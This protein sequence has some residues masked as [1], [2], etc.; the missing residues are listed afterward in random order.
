[1]KGVTF[2]R[3]LIIS[4]LLL[5]SVSGSG[6]METVREGLEESPPHGGRGI[7]SSSMNSVSEAVFIMP[8]VADAS[9]LTRGL[10]PGTHLHLLRPGE[11]LA[12][13][14]ELLA[15]Y[16][17]LATV[18][19]ISHGSPGTLSLGSTTLTSRNIAAY[20]AELTAMGRAIR[21]DGDILL[22]G[23]NVAEG[24][25]GQ[26]LVAG[27]A[28]WTA[29]DIAASTTLSGAA[30]R[31]GDWILES[32]SG[33]VTAGSLL[34]DETGY[35]GIL[36]T[37][38]V[39]NP[40][41]PI[42]VRP[43]GT[44]YTWTYGTGWLPPNPGDTAPVTQISYHEV[45]WN[46]AGA[47]PGPEDSVLTLGKF[48]YSTDGGGTWTDYAEGAFVPNVNTFTTNFV[49]VAG[50]IWRF[51]HTNPADT[52]SSNSIGFAYFVSGYGSSIGTSDSVH[53]DN[54]PTDISS[55]KSAMFSDVT[56]GTTIA[57][58]TPTDTG[59]TTG[60]YWAIDSQSVANLFTISFD[61]ATGNTATLQ[62]GTGTVPAGGET[63]TV[64]VRYYDPYQTDSSGNPIGGQGFAKTLPFAVIAETSQDLNFGDDLKVST[65]TPNDQLSPA[66]ASLS[67]GNFVVVWQSAGQGGET[68]ANNGIY[69][70][71]YDA[72]GNPVGGELAI[73]TAGNNI[74]ETAPAVTALNNGRFAVAYVTTPGANGLDIGYRIIEANG[75][76]GG[77]LIANTT[78]AGDQLQSTITTL[79]DGSFVLAWLTTDNSSFWNI[80]AQRFNAADGSKN[81]SELIVDTSGSDYTPYLCA[82]TNGAYV[83]AW[84]DWNT[85]NIMAVISSA[86]STVINVNN[87][88]AAWGMGP[89]MTGLIGGGFVVA[90]DSY[91]N[92]LTN[93]QQTDIFFQR[94]DNAGTA[95][96]SMTQV[97]ANTASGLYWYS[98]SVAP[99]SGGGFVVGW[100]S[101]ASNNSDYDQSGIFGRRFTAAGTAVDGSDFEINQHRRGDQNSPMVTALAADRFAAV[102]TDNTSDTTSAGIEGRVLLPSNTPPV[103]GGTFTTAGT[104]NDNATIAPFS[105]VTVSDADGDNVSI[106]LTYTAANGTL[107]GT[108]LTGAAGNYTV[109]AAAPAT[110]TANLQGL[111]F[112]PTAN[113]VAAG[114]TV[115][116]TFTLTPNDGTAN[117]TADSSTQVTATSVNNNPVITSNGGGATAS[118]SVN[119]NTTAVTTVTA[120]D[121][122]PATTLTYS[123]TGGAD[124]ARFTI[125][126]G[127]GALSFATAPNF[128]SPTD[129]GGNNVY[130]VQ[131]TVTDNG[132]GSLTDVQA[133]AVT[134][135]NINENPVISS[136]GGGASASV[137][138]P[139]NQTTV[140]TVTATDQDVADLLTYSITGGADAARFTI[141]GSSGVLTFVSAP[142]YESPTDGGGNN[143]YDVQVT[144]TDNGPGTLTD[145]QNIAVTVTNVNETPVITSNGGGATA[146]TAVNENTIAV[147]TV[148]ATD[149]DSDTLTYSISGGADAALF[150]INPASGALTFATAPDFENPT[151]TDANNIYDVQVTVTD[152]G[153]GNLTD[154]Q[155]LAVTVNN[156]NDAPVITSN[157]GGASASV[158]AAENQ[159]AVT[160]VSATDQDAGDTLSY[161]ISGGADAALFSINSGSGALTFIS[162]PD[163]ESPADSG[164]NNVYDVQ[165]TVTDSGTGNLTDIQNI[166]VTVTN[167]NEA[168]VITSNGGGASAGTTINENNPWVALVTATDPDAGDTQTY[169]ISGG[170][171]AALFSINSGSGVLTFL[172]APDFENPADVGGNNVYDVQVRVTDSG[173]LTD[174]QN[175]AVTVA[176][177]NE[178]PVITSNGGG[179]AASVNA[180]ENQTA[181]TTVTATDQDVGDTLSY[182]ISGGVD[183][184]LFSI[185]PASG[186]L[187]FIAAPDFEIPTDSDSNNVYDVQVRVT[188]SGTGNLFDT[189]NIAV[190]VT[191]VNEA[192]VITSNGGGATAATSVNENSTAVTTVTAT[193][194]DAGDTLTYSISGGADAARFSIN[195]GS[196]ALTFVT[197]PDFENPTDSSTNNVYDVQVTVTDSGTGNLTDV[198]DIAVTVTNVNDAPVITSN[199]GGAAASVSISEN[200]TVVTTVTA[201]DQDAADTLSYSITGGADAGLFSINSASGELT[202]IAAPDFETPTDSGSNNVYDVQ[203]RVTDSGT[204]NLTDTQN[205]A[206]TVTNANEAPT[207][208]SDGGGASGT[209]SVSE[210][211][212]AVTTVTA[213]DPDAADTLSYSISGGADASLFSINP[214]SGALAFITAPDSENPTDSDVNNIYEVQVQVTDSG[215]LTDLQDLAVTVDNANDAP[216]I[217]SD[218]GGAT[219][220]VNAAENQ[221]EVTTVIATD[222]DSGDTLNYSIVGGADAALF[223]IDGSSGALS[224]VTAP[225]F[226]NPA[227]SGGDNTYDVQVQV[228]DNGSGTLTDT[229]TIAVTVTS[230][231]EAPTITSNGGGASAA[232]SVNENTAAV[233][234]VTATDPDSGDSFIYS[235]SGGA[236]G[237]QFTISAGSGLLSFASAPDF[238][239]PADA[240]SD[241]VYNVQ[242]TVTDSGNLTDTQSIVVTVTNVN[243]APEF[244][245]TPAIN[246][247]ARAE[248]TVRLTDTGT[249]D[250]E[251]DPVTLTYQWQLDGIDI[252]GATTA[253]Y[254]IVADDLNKTITCTLTADDGKGGVTIF[255][256]AGKLVGKRFPWLILI[257]GL[258]S[259]NRVPEG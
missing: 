83:V 73:T 139:E 118:T 250:P 166:A 176:N 137:N 106:A 18:H 32:K 130:D 8:D 161:S 19:I 194:Q 71:I 101:S 79:T 27:L 173:T 162:A 95:Q 165:V 114:S 142:N 94:Y 117:G 245:G 35:E 30:A 97:N 52:T 178:A 124:A 16:R 171:D 223:S 116:T 26:E 164:S 157:G 64:T 213:T 28:R 4:S 96:G 225:D 50:K 12:R 188:D 25:E 190:T 189:Q 239:N 10:R 133:I 119:E 113:Q 200:G 198:Q 253:E 22:Y 168:P 11:G 138:A 40:G 202:F 57:T 203:V 131:V 81:G 199:G 87:D 63:P 41:G 31:G 104:V 45:N 76:V 14:A 219:A 13:I 15:G 228:A 39:L 149:P 177:V 231:N 224:F 196:G 187:T 185:D 70:Q 136:N 167:V 163:L 68:T 153:S 218:G 34:T 109:T 208:T 100:Q 91:A 126:S 46:P 62:I 191:S 90:W 186:A 211:T 17:D 145:V 174:Q 49:S 74:D 107:S 82:L 21:A 235:I 37:P 229:Q 121:V 240:G 69:G 160:T 201:T 3:A 112:T 80:S 195:P 209:T 75:T 134:V 127:S 89:R 20:G 111:V 23:C 234:T 36:A 47:T 151:D 244:T 158:N 24:T 58:L 247:E 233:A 38:K 92:D 103:L 257:P 143:V 66:V 241:N 243:E 206:V 42:Y 156:V 123:I 60:G 33:M 93:W 238:E 192:P 51:V 105:G 179:A 236:D 48:Q 204:G 217:T 86:W 84:S 216:V 108:G 125:N 55:D 9:T 128:E 172:T 152:S 98:P 249:V 154:I 88:G 150:S 222:Q 207:I 65:Y 135:T 43:G 122:D 197:A 169:S 99:L 59:M 170:V 129:S 54:A 252:P 180:A 184:G 242:V 258:V 132:P 102:W 181:V 251:D 2:R 6:A 120:T 77:Q 85:G 193:D 182:S 183:A 255:T 221:T 110:A 230:V 44:S 214:G 259:P 7:A 29:A 148:T 5:A 205:I 159:T 232:T 141:N 248:K 53:P 146:S 226:E 72:L 237:G 61:G 67:N 1:M 212:T 175:F 155:D 56:P 210:N 256:T 140:T 144:V 215:A 78:V 147:T 220:A 227:D 254:V 115:V 246:G